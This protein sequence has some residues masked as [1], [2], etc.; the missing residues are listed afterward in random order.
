MLLL[1]K[2]IK[3]F[4]A[5]EKADGIDPFIAGHCNLDTIENIDFIDLSKLEE[6][7]ALNDHLT[8]DALIKKSIQMSKAAPK[9][10]SKI[11]QE[12]KVRASA[13]DAE[14]K[15]KKIKQLRFRVQMPSLLY[16]YCNVVELIHLR[17]R[18]IKAVTETLV[19]SKVYKAQ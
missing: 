11:R 12:E 2:E 14:E 1:A 19:L 18:L 15:M 13:R 5:N 16:F 10:Q 6:D 4:S 9:F 8:L 3:S 17:E 7:P